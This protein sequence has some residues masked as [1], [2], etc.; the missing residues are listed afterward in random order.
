MA[1]KI[2]VVDDDPDILNLIKLELT[3]GGYDPV[4]C[5]NVKEAIDSLGK[6]HFE[7]AVLDIVMGVN[8]TSDVIVKF[9]KNASENILNFDLPL[10]II[11]AH[12]TP[13]LRTRM[14]SKDPL[15][16]DAL[17]KPLGKNQLLGKIDEILNSQLEADEELDV[18]FRPFGDSE[19]NERMVEEALEE[20]KEVQEYKRKK[21]EEKS[22]EQQAML[23]AGINQLMV[24]CFG[25]DYEAL[26]NHLIEDPDS[27]LMI[28]SLD[29]KT[30]M[31]YAARGGN[32][33]L[34]DFLLHSGLKI[35]ERDKKGREPLYE[36]V[37]V[38][39]ID[40]C[41]HLIHHGARTN[42]KFDEH[43]F[44]M[45]AAAVDDID[46]F[47]LFL[48]EGVSPGLTDKDGKTVKVHLKER[49]QDEFLKLL[50]KYGY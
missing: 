18:I 36:A 37:Q 31:H 41:K 20:S 32:Q 38:K 23:E 1:S 15:I 33:E 9:L 3:N 27:N 5:Q 8:E 14:I 13:D 29:G 47:N 46:I 34:V 7:C 11:S 22:A 48:Q 24:D 28:R 17:K 43:T 19:E 4:L 16:V 12:V 45:V 39:D 2:L 40:M 26:Q 30:C 42:S 21:A 25:G 10:I 35:N 49:K 44:L 50:E 6:H